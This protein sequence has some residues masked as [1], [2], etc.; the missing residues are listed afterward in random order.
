MGSL[1]LLIADHYTFSLST[2]EILAAAGLAIT[3]LG[4]MWVLN[5]WLID[6]RVDVKLE[7]TVQQA[8]KR[9][10]EIVD[11]KMDTMLINQRETSEALG[12]VHDL[13]VTINNGLTAKV[14]EIDR[15]V[16]QII[17][18]QLGWEVEGGGTH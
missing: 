10:V 3:V 7:E 9:H 15:K 14:S 17:A 5:G 2:S 8:V 12:R 4:A 1:M 11:T 18:H 16:D 6:R 13:E